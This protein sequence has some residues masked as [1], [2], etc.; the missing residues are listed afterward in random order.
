M[1]NVKQQNVEQH[2]CPNCGASL[3]YDPSSGKLVCEHCGSSI[4]FEKSNA[5]EER[6]FTELATFSHWKDSDVASHNIIRK[7]IADNGKD[8]RFQT[9]EH[10]VEELRERNRDNTTVG[11]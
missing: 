8:Y 9:A 2:N 10:P 6:D 7:Y 11:R 5:V 4:D 3:Q 1:Q